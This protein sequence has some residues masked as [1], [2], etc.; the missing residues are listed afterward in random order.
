M[1]HYFEAFD[2]PNNMPAVWKQHFAFAQEL[3]TPIVIGEIG[4]DYN[5]A[6]KTWQDWAI[7]FMK[8]NGFGLFYFALNPDSKDTGGLVP[9]DWSLPQQGTPEY[10]KLQA[11]AGLPST[12]VFTVCPTCRPPPQSAP[13]QQASGSATWQ[14]PIGAVDMVLIVA[15][16]VILGVVWLNRLKKGRRKGDKVPTTSDEDLESS[17]RPVPAVTNTTNSLD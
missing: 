13:S 2:F 16:V 12:K 5:G 15:V 10:D 3:G 17:C 4:G 7:P 9:K 1:Q 14:P 6:D 8:Q 11:L